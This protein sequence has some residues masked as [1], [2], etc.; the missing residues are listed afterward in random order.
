LQAAL[1]GRGSPLYGLTWKPW[2]MESG[3]P[4]CALRASAPRTSDS[5][6]GGEAS[7]WMTPIV[8]DAKHSGTAKSGPGRA[9][10]LVYEAQLAGWPTPT[11]S[12][13][14]K[15]VRSEAGA[16]REAMRSHGPDLAAAV[17]LAG[18]PTPTAAAAHS[19]PTDNAKDT[20]RDLPTAALQAGWATPCALDGKGL[21]TFP[22]HSKQKNLNRDLNRYLVGHEA[23]RLTSTGEMLTGSDAGMDGGG[24][25]NP[26]HARWLMGYPPVWDDCAATA[27]PSS[28][29]SRRRS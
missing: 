27:T 9:M 3:P 2:A 20:N 13:A 21:S 29:K 25:L 4:I 19:Y 23:A 11:S 7:G 10:K 18:W 8:Q 24:R 1:A 16:I 28:P 17:S 6:C 22:I 5:G 14:T 15:G 26:A 12:L